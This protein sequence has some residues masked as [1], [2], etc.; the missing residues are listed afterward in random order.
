MCG[1][2][3]SACNLLHLLWCWVQ[4]YTFGSS[5]DRYGRNWFNVVC[6]KSLATYIMHGIGQS[7]VFIAVFKAKR[8]I[9][10]RFAVAKGNTA[11]LNPTRSL[12]KEYLTT[13]GKPTQTG[14]TAPMASL[15]LNVIAP[16]ELHTCCICLEPYDE[17]THQAKFLTC[18]HTFCSY[19]LDKLSQKEVNSNVILCP[20]CRAHTELST[21]G[22]GGLQTNFYI[23]SFQEFSRNTET[24]TASKKFQDCP[25]NNQPISYFCMTCGISVCHVCTTEDHTAMNGHSVVRTSKSETLYLQE[26]NIS[27]KSLTINKRN[28]QLIETELALLDA[29]KETALGDMETFIKLAQDQL[30]QRRNDHQKEILDLFITKQTILHDKQNEIQ[31][32]IKLIDDSITQAQITTQTGDVRKLKAI[33]DSLKKA[34]AKTQSFSSHPDLG[35]DYLVFDANKAL[36]EFTECLCTLGQPHYGGFLPTVIKFPALE[37][38]VGQKTDLPVE[39][40]NH[41]GDKI[42]VPC[43]VFQYK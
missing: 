9:F 15:Q 14:Y 19:C 21:N 38:K 39:V 20:N 11:A 2:D 4:I 18:H 26:L 3:V 34:N 24:R 30:E 10:V 31:T 42:S 5:F 33:C 12:S 1:Y 32:T 40:K 35:E 37:L 28:L 8:N 22:V 23:T 29:A 17:N 13:A 36:D 7:Y 41:Q 43:D 27:H 16:D 6:V 25:H